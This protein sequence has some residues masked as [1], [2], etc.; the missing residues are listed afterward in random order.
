MTCSTRLLTWI[1]RID[2]ET[3]AEITEDPIQSFPSIKTIVPAADASNEDA[4]MTND[5]V[6]CECGV[7]V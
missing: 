4:I 7:T 2:M 1:L 5:V 3:Q 6:E